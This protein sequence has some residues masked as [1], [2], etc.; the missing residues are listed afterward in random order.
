MGGGMTTILADDRVTGLRVGYIATDWNSLIPFKQYK[1]FLSDWSVQ[2]IIRDGK[3][4]GAVFKKDGEVHVSI[5]KPWRRRWMTKNLIKEILSS[6]S[7]T[8]VTPGHEHYMSSILQRLGMTQIEQN[9]FALK[10]I[11]HGY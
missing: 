11:Y 3:A 5:V 8:V 2:T 10:G 7:Y 1:D 6:A 9:K 4:I